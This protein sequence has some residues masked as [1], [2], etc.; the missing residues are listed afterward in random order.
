MKDLQTSLAVM[1]ILLRE[2]GGHGSNNIFN[3]NQIYLPS[4]LCFDLTWLTI[5]IFN[6]TIR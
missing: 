1:F 6:K 2:R 5:N 4:R 3:N